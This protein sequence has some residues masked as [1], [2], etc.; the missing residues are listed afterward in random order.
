MVHR[1]CLVCV[2]L[3][4]LLLTASRAAEPKPQPSTISMVLHR[5]SQPAPSPPR[6]PAVQ[7]RTI[8]PLP[9][10]TLPACKPLD[11]IAVGAWAP[12]GELPPDLSEHCFPPVHYP[13]TSARPWAE[14][15]YAWEAPGLYHLPLYFEDVA[16][17]R[18]GHTICPLAQPAISAAHFFGTAPLLPYKMGLEPPLEHVYTL[19]YYRPGNHAPRLIYPLP[20]RADAAALQAGAVTGLIFLIP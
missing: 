11:Q 10:P 2:C 15:S 19:G 16:L 4:T 20:L 18:Y 6:P 17:E 5:A 3:S 12:H 7:Q 9:S 14:F 1:V 13:G 8:E